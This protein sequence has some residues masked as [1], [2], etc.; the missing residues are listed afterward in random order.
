MNLRKRIREDREREKEIKRKIKG[1]QLW[2]WEGRRERSK[3]EIKGKNTLKHK[4]KNMR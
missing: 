4:K 1:T 3:K 2:V